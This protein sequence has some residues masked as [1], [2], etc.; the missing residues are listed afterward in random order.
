MLLAGGPGVGY[1]AEGNNGAQTDHNGTMTF[2][3]AV[4][5]A[6]DTGRFRITLWF[7]RVYK[8]LAAGGLSHETGRFRAVP[9][10]R[11]G[12]PRD[13]AS[14]SGRYTIGENFHASNNVA[15]GTFKFRVTGTSTTGE[16]INGHMLFHMTMVKGEAKVEL[17][18]VRCG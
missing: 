6:S 4:P 5:C 13:G 10:T 7:N 2:V 8:G 9:V 3:E 18:K 14:Y 11:T 1:A 15:V 16:R 17:E 12:A